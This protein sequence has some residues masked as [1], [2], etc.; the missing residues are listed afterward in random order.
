MQRSSFIPLAALLFAAC[1]AS[2]H[3]ARFVTRDPRPPGQ[4]VIVYSSKLPECAYE[5]IGVVTGSP[6]TGFTSMQDVLEAVRERARKLG[7]DA[8]VGL[9]PARHV[10]GA[11]VVGETISIDSKTSLSG[12]VVRFTDEGCRR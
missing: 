4:E 2:V 8:I 11:S 9:G 5:E 7:G 10:S 1:G 6:R 12:T 3:S